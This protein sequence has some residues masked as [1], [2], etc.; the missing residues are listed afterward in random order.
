LSTHTVIINSTLVGVTLLA[1]SVA[2]WAGGHNEGD[3]SKEWSAELGAAVVFMPDYE[4]SD[5][6]ENVT[7]PLLKLSWQDRILVTTTDGPGIYARLPILENFSA[8]IGVRY[9]EDR[10]ERD[11]DVLAGLGDLKVGAVGVGKLS[12][13]FGSVSTS[14]QLN[15]DLEGDRDGTIVKLDANYRTKIMDEKV[16]VSAGLFMT[17]ANDDYMSNVFGITSAQAASSKAGLSKFDAEAGIKDVGIKIML[18]YDINETVSA[19][20]FAEYSHLLGDAVDSPLVDSQ[21]SESQALIGF[22]IN[23]KW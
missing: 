15:Y 23:Y 4:G 19:V 21:G 14:V 7:A 8:D 18:S 13:K 5:D 11:N 9:S 6:Y 22:G 3:P 2:A 20:T 17:W 1:T 10:D 16:S 12:Y